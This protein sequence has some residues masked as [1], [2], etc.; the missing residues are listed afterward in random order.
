MSTRTRAQ[1]ATSVLRKLGILDANSSPSAADSDYVISEYDDMLA[2]LESRD[3][4]YWSA[5]EIPL[6]IFG[7]VVRLIA[8]EVAPAFGRG[9]NVTDQ[10]AIRELLMK[11]IIQHV[12]RV[13]SGLPAKAK[14]Y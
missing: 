3:R 4:A 5:D 11:P 13:P 1:L 6:S 9:T 2:Y 10:E 7:P 14:H 12:A 8:N